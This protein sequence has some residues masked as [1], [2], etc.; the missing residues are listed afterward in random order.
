[1][2]VFLELYLKNMKLVLFMLIKIGRKNKVFQEAFSRSKSR[3]PLSHYSESVN[4]K[5]LPRQA[6]K[7]FLLAYLSS[8]G[9][10]GRVMCWEQSC[11]LCGACV[12]FRGRKWLVQFPEFSLIEKN[13]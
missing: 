13:G 7:G 9:R 12:F 3:H 6:G 10:V 8:G 2:V 1:M 11:C 4:I 5:A